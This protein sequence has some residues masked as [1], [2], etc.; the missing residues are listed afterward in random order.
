M[1]ARGEDEAVLFLRGAGQVQGGTDRRGRRRRASR[2]LRGEGL[3]RG[4]LISLV[5]QLTKQTSVMGEA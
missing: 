3:S 2:C 1:A 5:A 4:D